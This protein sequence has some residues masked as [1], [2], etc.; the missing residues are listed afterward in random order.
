MNLQALTQ[1]ATE[2]GCEVAAL[3]A[4]AEVESAGSGFLP[5]GRPKI[6]FEAHIFSAR[7]RHRFD[8]SHPDISSP[9]WNRSLYRGGPAE[10]DRLNRAIQLAARAALESASWG[11]FQLMGFKFAACGFP[12]VETMVA[13]MKSEAG[14]LWAFA[15]FILSSPAMH[16]ALR[17]K[18][19]QR[20]TRLYN[21]PGQVAVYAA[22]IDD[23]Y[24]VAVGDTEVPTEFVPPVDTATPAKSIL[25]SKTAIG[26]TVGIASGAA[27]IADQAGTIS[28]A[29]GNTTAAVGAA[30][31]FWGTL[32]AIFGGPALPWALF[33]ICV[34]AFGFV[35]WRYVLKARVGDVIIR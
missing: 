25:V 22:R 35:L 1:A 33:A 17:A 7:T 27:A 24:R 31:G 32:Q 28:A 34:L 9:T 23:A 15:R 4:V 29:I 18:D 14:Q 26:S 30:R 5:D 13:A 21:G 8:A 6:L 12:D 3:R 16:A 11:A 10:H 2:L 19:W 20:F